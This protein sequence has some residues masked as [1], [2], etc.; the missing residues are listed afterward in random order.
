[1][2][3]SLAM[4]KRLAEAVPVVLADTLN[5]LG[6]CANLRGDYD[7]SLKYYHQ[8]LSELR[9]DDNNNNTSSN[10]H[11][12]N[13]SGPRA[14]QVAN[15]LFNIGRL[16]I[17]RREWDNALDAL[18]EAWRMTRDVW[19]NSHV[20]VAQTLDL[21]GFVQISTKQYD[22][23]IIS[24]T[25]ALSIYRRINGPLH[26]DVASA[27]FN[28]GMVREARGDLDDA[29]EAYKTARD[30]HIRLGTLEEDPGFTT[31]RHSIASMQ[32]SLTQKKLAHLV[33]KH[34]GTLLKKKQA[35]GLI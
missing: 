34:Q 9:D 7:E 21:L 28:V 8:A 2:A 23:A 24:F 14:A 27:L 13:G 4:K 31:V 29:L 12:G 3:E 20:Y 6:N 30:L 22:S 1:L 10:T 18:S 32:K 35:S 25:G 19:G 17:Q 15:L 5:N 33:A 26:P 16:E 11:R